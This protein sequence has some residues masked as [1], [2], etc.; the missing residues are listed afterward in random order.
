[1]MKNVLILCFLA[2]SLHVMA[3]P[4]RW[5]Q[6]VKYTMDVKMNVKTNQY[7][8]IQKLEYWNNSPDTLKR[9]FYHLYWNAFQPNSMM[10]VRSQELGKIRIRATGDRP[11]WDT[12][13][14]DR[15][16]NLKEDEVGYEKVLSLKMNG[17][18]QKYVVHETILEVILNK[19]ILPK[20]KVTFDMEMEAQVHLQIRRSGRDNP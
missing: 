3:Q 2:S 18:A 19:P 9:V 16:A 5:Q 14:R 12:R 10:D 6:R 8:G 11:D 7:K 1:M 13:V 17:V 4:D 20:S 15:I